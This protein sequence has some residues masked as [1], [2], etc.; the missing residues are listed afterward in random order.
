MAPLIGAFLTQPNERYEV[1][2][3]GAPAGVYEGYCQPHL[4]FGMRVTITV[5]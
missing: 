5:R 3:A 1:S 4:V 2:F